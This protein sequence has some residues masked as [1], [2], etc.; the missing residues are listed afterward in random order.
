MRAY[1]HRQGRRT[2]SLLTRISAAPLVAGV[3]A[4]LI[5]S[6]DWA[7]H[8]FQPSWKRKGGQEVIWDLVDIA[9]NKPRPWNGIAN[10]SLFNVT[11]MSSQNRLAE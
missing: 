6:G 5:V 4:N 11:G 9:N 10:L 3:L 1:N 8:H 7:F 2:C